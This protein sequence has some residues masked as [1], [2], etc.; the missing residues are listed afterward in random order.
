MNT[1]PL[2]NKALKHFYG[3]T[4]TRYDL[5]VPHV[6]PEYTE[7]TN[8]YTLLRVTHPEP[9]K[10]VTEY[11]NKEVWPDTNTVLT[12]NQ[13]KEVVTIS[14]DYL[15]DIV[16]GLKA[17]AK[18]HGHEKPGITLSIGEKAGWEPLTFKMDCADNTKV[19][20]LLMPIR[21]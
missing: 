9:L 5:S 20:A 4:N 11:P 3:K 16:K 10:N 7:A 18:L 6:T 2:D 1:T 21:N 12:M 15:E 17:C 8:S 19:T 13:E 14:L